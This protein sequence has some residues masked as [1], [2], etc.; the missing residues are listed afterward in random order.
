THR[1]RIPESSPQ[2]RRTV[3]DTDRS[4][5]SLGLTVLSLRLASTF[6]ESLLPGFAASVKSLVDRPNFDDYAEAN[7]RMGRKQLDCLVH[8]LKS[9]HHDA[10]Q[11][12]LGFGKRAVR[13][14][15]LVALRTQYLR[16]P[17]AL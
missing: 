1:R 2:D 7:G 3:V 10:T 14:N 9:V 15:N 17:S 8:V 13:N 4:M 6:L 5:R 11:L 16:G 12:F